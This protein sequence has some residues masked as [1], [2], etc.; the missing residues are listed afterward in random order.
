MAI[1]LP[2][3][4]LSNVIR[5]IVTATIVHYFGIGS[6]VWAHVIIGRV[7]FYGLTIMLYYMVFTRVQVNNMRVGKFSFKKGED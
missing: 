3:I 7:I 6:L 4:Y 2:C 5:L 1:G